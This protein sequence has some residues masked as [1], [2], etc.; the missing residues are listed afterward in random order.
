MLAYIFI[1]WEPT[2]DTIPRTGQNT[3][4]R[5]DQNTYLYIDTRDGYLSNT[6]NCMTQL[7]H[8]QISQNWEVKI[9]LDKNI[10]NTSHITADIFSDTKKFPVV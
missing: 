3:Y 8:R 7:G 6:K 10:F 1:S 4:L 5:S 2:V 9:N